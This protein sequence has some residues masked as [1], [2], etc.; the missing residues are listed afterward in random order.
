LTK[1]Q[2]K[3]IVSGK[4]NTMC[5]DKTGTLTED[6]LDMYGVK[7]VQ[8]Q[9]GNLTFK[10]T[11]KDQYHQNLNGDHED[12]DSKGISQKMLELMATC[13]SLA[14]IKGSLSGKIFS[15]DFRL[16]Y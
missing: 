12:N 1:S 2:T 6:S 4:V 7:T 10:K 16:N 3:I 11:V 8:I 14:Y 15:M 5:F 13:H 9:N